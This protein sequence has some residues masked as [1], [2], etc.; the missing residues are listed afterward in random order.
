MRSGFWAVANTVSQQEPRAVFK[1]LMAQYFSGNAAF[2]WLCSEYLP[3]DSQ[4]SLASVLAIYR[5]H[6]PDISLTA[7]VADFLTR[8]KNNGIRMG[9]VTDGRSIAQR[10]KIEALKLDRW[11]EFFSVSEECG[12]EKPSEQPFLG[13]MERFDC[14]NFVYIADNYNKDFVAPNRLGWRTIAL[15][16]NGLNIHDRKPA[17]DAENHPREVIRSFTELEVVDEQQL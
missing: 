4:H 10:N 1:G 6:K 15:A 8:L 3:A 13:F 7:E 9:L 14:K 2:N 12:F 5:N 11:I 16:D 17:L